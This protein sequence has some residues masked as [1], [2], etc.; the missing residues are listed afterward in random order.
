MSVLAASETEEEESGGGVSVGVTATATTPLSEKSSPASFC[1]DSLLK[2]PS[3]SRQ[4]SPTLSSST[5]TGKT[6]LLM[7]PSRGASNG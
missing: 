4:Q 7:L 2:A 3:P 1:I 5:I 6:K